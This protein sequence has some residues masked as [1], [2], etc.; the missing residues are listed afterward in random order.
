MTERRDFR[1]ASTK[2]FPGKPVDSAA[3]RV[4]FMQDA[5]TA[6]RITWRA[7]QLLQAL[8]PVLV[9]ITTLYAAYRGM[10]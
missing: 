8:H 9:D 1:R 5:T 2:A 10:R 6:E 4:T 7:A 3:K